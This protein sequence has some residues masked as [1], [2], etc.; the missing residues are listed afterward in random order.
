MEVKIIPTGGLCNRLRAIATGIAVAERYQSEAIIYWNNSIG[1]KADFKDLFQPINNKHITLKENQKWI[2]KIDGTKDYLKR[3]L[4]LH[5]LSEQCIF[6]YSIYRSNSDIYEKLKK[7]YKN[8]LL[9]ISCYPM[10][11]EYELKN[12]FVPQLDIQKRIDKVVQNFTKRT[13]GIHI[14]RTDNIESIKSSPLEAFINSINAELK[15]D[16]NT[17]FYLASDDD[18]VKD[19]LEE[20]F[21]DSIITIRED[22]DRNTLEGMKFAVVDLFC[23]SKTQKIIGSVFSSYSQIAAELGDIEIEYAKI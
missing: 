16:A 1:L 3:A 17:K 9:L 8:T 20:K 14:R 21:P 4:L 5:L 15:K 11:K 2:Y 6:N 22:V 19:I 7:Q 10:C 23:L 12:I 18:H 13:I